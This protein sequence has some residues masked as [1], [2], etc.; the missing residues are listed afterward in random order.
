VESPQIKPGTEE[1]EDFGSLL[2]EDDSAMEE[3]VF[4]SSLE[5]ETFFTLLEDPSTG[6]GSFELDVV[7]SSRELDVVVSV[8]DEEPVEFADA[9]DDD[10]SALATASCIR[11]MS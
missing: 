6:S 2:L 8:S 4:S 5:L 3:L 9:I 10:V 7:S 11:S 1:L